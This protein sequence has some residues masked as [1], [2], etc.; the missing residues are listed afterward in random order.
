MSVSARCRCGK[1]EF[2]SSEPPL[3]Q[4]CCHCNDCREATSNDFTTIAFFDRSATSVSGTVSSRNFTTAAGME[5]CREFCAT[6]NTVMFDKSD[7]F[8]TLLGVVA[9]QIAAPLEAN[10]SHHVWVKSK[11]PHVSIPSSAQAFEE[12]LS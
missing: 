6:C 11:L 10:P 12:N 9:E 7:G 1:V 8:P 4:L 3:I 2:S 5:T